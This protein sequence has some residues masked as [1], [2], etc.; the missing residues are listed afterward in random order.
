MFPPV[1]GAQLSQ[2][3]SCL[4]FYNLIQASAASQILSAVKICHL[5]S[6]LYI[7][8][9]VPK[10]LLVCRSGTFPDYLFMLHEFMLHEH[11]LTR[12]SSNEVY[13]PPKR[14]RPC[15]GSMSLF[16]GEHHTQLGITHP[17]TFT[18]SLYVH[19]K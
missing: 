5:L 15:P 10:N 2:Q 18:M 4:F 8:D 9:P 14:D 11:R 1:L 16:R 13:L 19:M 7:W 6:Q 12:N 17:V 3:V